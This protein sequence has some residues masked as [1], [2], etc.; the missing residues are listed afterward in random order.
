MSCSAMNRAG[1]ALP[2]LCCH[3]T[4]DALESAGGAFVTL[5][6]EDRERP[7]QAMKRLAVDVSAIMPEK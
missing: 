6:A 7:W 1:A 5:K 2:G 3:G 4:D